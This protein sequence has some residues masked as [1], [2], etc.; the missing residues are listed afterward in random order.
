MK[1]LNSAVITM[2]LFIVTSCSLIDKSL[3]IK[4]PADIVTGEKNKFSFV[5]IGDAGKGNQ[6]QNL[7]AQAIKNKCAKDG[8][9]FVI[10]LGDNIYQTGVASVDDSQFQ[11]KFEIP[12]KDISVPFYMTLGNHDYGGAGYDIP[13][14]IYQVKYTEKS[15][16]WRM[17]AHFYQ[18]QVDNTQFISLDTNAQ[19]FS[20]ADEQEKQVNNWLVQSNSEWKIVFGHHPYKSNGR[21]GNAGRYEGVKGVPIVSGKGVKDFSESVWCGKADL[22]LSGHD[23]NRQWLDVSC[24]GTQLALSGAAASTTK[25][26]GKNPSL[27]ESDELGFLY[28]SI[29]NKKLTAEFI[30]VNGQVNLVLYYYH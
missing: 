7:V 26:V 19:M 11:S 14:S 15:D 27:F 30:D 6:G 23:H 10:M 13:K 28:V 18:F 21:H 2:M 25:L 17:P 16:K 29:N 24:K 1:Y 8:C 9:D 22:Y 20:Y 5:A 12:Y 3:D 4:A